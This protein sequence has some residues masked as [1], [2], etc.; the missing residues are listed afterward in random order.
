MNAPSNDEIEVSLFGPV[1]GYGESIAL[2]CCEG[3]WI[4]VDSCRSSGNNAPAA[5]QYLD[6]IGVDVATAVLLVVASHW[7]TDH[8]DGLA[9]IFS[10]CEA[11]ELVFSVA[12]RS[13]ELLQI[14]EAFKKH[15]SSANKTGLEELHG[16]IGVLRDRSPALHYKH[17]KSPRW[18][19]SH[20]TLFP[21]PYIQGLDCTVAALSPSDASV[22]KAHEELVSL[23]DENT[24]GPKK[25][26]VPRNPN[27]NAIVL[28]VRIGKHSILLGSDLQ[29]TKDPGTGWSVLLDE[30]DPNLSK[31]DVYKI[32]HH[33]SVTGEHPEI[34]NRLVTPNPQALLTPFIKGGVKLPTEDDVKRMKANTSRCYMTSDGS[35]KHR[36]YSRANKEMIQRAT[37]R[38]HSIDRTIGH[39]RITC[40]MSSEPDPTNWS[41]TMNEHAVKL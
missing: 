37:R 2:H 27:H 39:V 16:L 23:R 11:A 13:E 8:I 19:K 9:T 30:A 34:W 21:P 7:H 36:K 15:P 24:R 22:L 17:R 3:H 6:A 35:L 29:V 5:L 25:N 32:S 4:I 28:W 31:A 1:R 33:G 18:A 10:R 38:F 20:T 26:L 14:Y 41:V 12:L 40:K